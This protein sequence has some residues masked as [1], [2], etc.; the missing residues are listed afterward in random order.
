M[1]VGDQAEYEDDGAELCGAFPLVFAAELFLHLFQLLL[2]AHGVFSKLINL[3]C[4]HDHH[5]RQE[6]QHDAEADET[7]VTRVFLAFIARPGVEKPVFHALAAA[8][9]FVSRF[10]LV[11]S[12][13]PFRR[14]AH[15][16][17]D[18]AFLVLPLPFRAFFAS[19]IRGK[20]IASVPAWRTIF[21]FFLLR[22]KL[23]ARRARLARTSKPW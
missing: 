23:C 5:D 1:K 20:V 9:T 10:A 16:A 4:K 13:A 8:K 12:G 19:S 7:V 14:V 11:A 18:R 22:H 17:R 15:Q 2:G 21:T 6:E 3:V